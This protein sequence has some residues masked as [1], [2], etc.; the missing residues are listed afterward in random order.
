MAETPIDDTLGFGQPP[1]TQPAE[2]GYDPLPRISSE[3]EYAALSAGREYLDPAGKT[4]RKPYMVRDKRSYE[5]VPEGENYIDPTGQSRT[6]PKYDGIDFTTQTLYDMSI[7]DK[8]RRKAL[9][10]TYPG[11][12]KGEGEN[13]YVEDEG[14]VLRKPGRGGLMKRGGAAALGMA[15]PMT[16]AVLGTIGGA[17]AAAPTGPGAIAGGAA[18]GAGG[19]VIGQ[20]FNDMVL[21]LSGVYD[22]SIGEEAGNLGLAGLTSAAGSGVGRGIATIAPAAKGLLQ[23]GG[24]ALP[25]MVGGILGADP[26]KLATAADVASR[27]AT[28]I[29]PSSVF[30]EAPYLHTAVETFD[31]KFRSQNVIRQSAED[32]YEDQAGKVL[33]QVG[34]PRAVRPGK[35]ADPEAAVSSER[36]GAA[37]LARTSQ[38]MER[39]DAHLEAAITRLRQEVASGREATGAS[40]NASVEELRKAADASRGAAQNAI[41]AGFKSIEGDA[42]QA[43]KVAEVG[44]NSGELWQAV[45]KKLQ[46]VRTGIMTR[47]KK[48]YSAADEASGGMRPDSE[49]I[50]DLARAFLSEMPE[51]F[52]SKYPDIVRKLEAWGG[53]TDEAGKVVAE[54]V[55]PT[56]GE[57][58]NVRSELRSNVDYYDL[59]PGQREGAY[60]YFAKR[61]D[62]ALHDPNAPEQLKK[63]AGL[64]DDADKFYAQNM[65]AFKDRNLQS[66][67]NALESGLMPDPK[68]LANTLLKEGRTE[69][70]NKVKGMIGPNLWGAVK[71]ADMQEMLDLSKTLV[72]GQVDG[73]VFARQ[74][75]ERIKSGQLEAVYDKATAEKLRAQAQYVAMMDGKVP[76]N[77][78]PG[79]TIATMIERARV[80]ADAAK[81]AAKQDPL[82]SLSRE[83]RQIDAMANRKA[84]ELRRA[85]KDDPLGFLYDRTV[86]ASEAADRVLADKDLIFAAASKFGENSPE[87]NMLRQVYAQRL[88]QGTLDPGEKLAKVTPEIQRIMFPGASLDEMQTLAKNMD[89][90]L[91]SKAA[92]ADAGSSIAAQSRVLNP[93]GS[94]TGLGKFAKPLK[95]IPGVETA[96]RFI[97]TQYYKI[98]SDVASSPATMQWLAKGLNGSPVDREAVKAAIQRAQRTGQ[99]I[100]AAISEGLYQ[101]R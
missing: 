88:L 9:E 76:V 43:M 6:K 5:S 18:G 71:A 81:A 22:R 74:V 20:M 63:A 100:G 59:T 8:E 32:F 89:F 72:P 24:A 87:F 41:D 68:L 7:T 101:N 12:V 1:G 21:R 70:I 91:G 58:R 60:K 35:L 16:G 33:D 99:P 39:Q 85:R 44:G 64:L 11:K 38:E 23:S 93:W 83:T 84:A 40:W 42:A 19:G 86:G 48:M 61:V 52:K 31:P 75:E 4:R 2:G 62:E 73:K 25:K 14:G 82:G 56:F 30:M 36:A 26:A 69:L 67:V 10:R 51:N 47:A 79:D 17:A 90:L 15:A 34:V 45:G 37:L 94:I 78:R 28:K 80:E 97:L 46:S 13:L 55:K 77:A 49:G 92:R 66:V 53:K 57:L 96:G 54:P 95:V 65:A 3:G 27:G 98:L 29:P 50:P